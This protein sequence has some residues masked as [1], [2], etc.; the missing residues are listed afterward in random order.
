M[1]GYAPR[2]V[3]VLLPTLLHAS[4]GK[5]GVFDVLEPDDA[6]VFWESCVRDW[7]ERFARVP[8]IERYVLVRPDDH[9]YRSD[10]QRWGWTVLPTW[11]AHLD[12]SAV[13]DAAERALVNADAVLLVSPVAPSVPMRAVHQLLD[14]LGA[15]D[16]VFGPTEQEGYWAV[17]ARS[18]ALQLLRQISIGSALVQSD[19]EE[20]CRHER[21]S[22]AVGETWFELDT[23]ADVQRLAL[24]SSGTASSA[25]PVSPRSVEFARLLLSSS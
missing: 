11:S 10:A 24:E 25:Y 21:A 7:M 19:L 8:N 2:R 18:H 12:A 3:A 4:Q 23:I 9:R 5:Q 13:V 6:V 15:H 20:H 17:A 14:S 16:V 22:F 1:S